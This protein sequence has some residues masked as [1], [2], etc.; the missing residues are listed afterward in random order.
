[1]YLFVCLFSQ[2]HV[3]MCAC[4]DCHFI[5]T[6]RK[7][8]HNV[9]FLK[10]AFFLSIVI[11]PFIIR[12]V[13]FRAKI[14][15]SYKYYYTNHGLYLVYI[16]VTVCLCIMCMKLCVCVYYVYI[17]GTGFYSVFSYKGLI[18]MLARATLRPRTAMKW[19]CAE[20]A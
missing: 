16:H 2:W 3:C 4:L 14:Q 15:P 11:L 6:K 7:F 10:L 1:M 17:L 13:Y 19:K 9:Q 20:S 12:S 18:H 8:I 5:F